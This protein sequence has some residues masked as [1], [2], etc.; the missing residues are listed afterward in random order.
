MN[1]ARTG[2]RLAAIFLSVLVSGC[3][4]LLPKTQ[5]AQLYRF[6]LRSAAATAKPA[7]G[8]IGV[9]LSDV[10]LPA[11]SGGNDILTIHGDEAAYVKDARWVSSATLLFT[12]AAADAF[13]AKSGP[14]R[15]LAEGES[16]PAAYSLRL[17]V[18]RFEVDYGSGPTP[19][20]VIEVY[21]SLARTSGQERESGY[22]FRVSTPAAEDRMG[23]IVEAY[24]QAT[25]TVL[26]QIVD[27]VNATALA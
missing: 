3:V 11:A 14:A 17:D 22:L 5:P 4:T 20:V 13:A 25:E 15:L 26:V 12:A 19:I 21:A 24:D 1:P 10:T 16:G 27:W 23:A 7:N 8:A 9:R 18:R 2:G 6:G